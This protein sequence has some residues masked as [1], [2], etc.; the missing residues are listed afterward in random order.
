[1]VSGLNA[2]AKV[3]QTTVFLYYKKV[4]WHISG[5][6]VVYQIVKAYF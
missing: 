6:L 5:K 3:F 2:R 1:M 4:K